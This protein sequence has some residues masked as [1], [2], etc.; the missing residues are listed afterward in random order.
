MQISSMPLGYNH[1]A[2][3]EALADPVNQ[4]SDIKALR[5]GVP[6]FFHIRNLHANLLYR[7]YHLSSKCLIFDKIPII[8]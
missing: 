5:R 7:I 6:Y 3:L 1:P 2:M 4:V 8:R